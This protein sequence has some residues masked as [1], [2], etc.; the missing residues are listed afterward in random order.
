MLVTT[1]LLS[2]K[3][4][5]G[6]LIGIQNIQSLYQSTSCISLAILNAT[7]S[8]PKVELSIVFY[9]HEYQITGVPLRKNI[10]PVLK[11]HIIKSVALGKS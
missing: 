2:Q 11:L 1:L 7:N 4:L 3:A 6:P 10:V 8:E 5:V 9:L